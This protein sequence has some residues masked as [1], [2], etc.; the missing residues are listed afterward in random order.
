MIQKVSK[1]SRTEYRN[2]GV[3]IRRWTH[4]RLIRQKLREQTTLTP[5]GHRKDTE[6]LGETHDYQ[7][8]TLLK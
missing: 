4:P 6:N 2:Y 1:A 8:I 3:I 7:R 5:S